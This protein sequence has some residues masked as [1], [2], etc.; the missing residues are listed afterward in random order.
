MKGIKLWTYALLY[1]M[2]MLTGVTLLLW[3]LAV[4]IGG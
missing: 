3:L 1:V 4:I 2:M